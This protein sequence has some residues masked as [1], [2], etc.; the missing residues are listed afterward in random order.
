MTSSSCVKFA[1]TLTL[2]PS[3]YHKSLG[4]QAKLMCDEISR[5][6]PK[7]IC[8]LTSVMEVTM[9]GNIHVHGI[10][11]F[12][13]LKY[14]HTNNY[15]LQNIK[16]TSKIIGF[17]MVKDLTSEQEWLKYILKDIDVTKHLLL[18]NCYHPCQRDDFNLVHCMTDIATIDELCPDDFRQG[19]L[20]K[21][22]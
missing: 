13:S 21:A 12:R 22:Q 15:T 18:T 7:S 10:M 5:L 19:A 8:C 9:Q 16:R 20:Q 17:C 3:H 14:L 1:Y 6:F 4:E 11:R 2:K